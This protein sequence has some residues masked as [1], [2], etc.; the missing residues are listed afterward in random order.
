VSV[1]PPDSLIEPEDGCPQC[2]LRHAPGELFA[3]TG[4]EDHPVLDDTCELEPAWR[5]AHDAGMP[6]RSRAYH[7]TDSLEAVLAQG[8]D[9]MQTN[10]DC[11]HMPRRNPGDRRVPRG[12]WSPE[13][14]ALGITRAEG[15]G[16]RDGRPGEHPD[17]WPADIE[18]RQR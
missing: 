5:A 14:F 16:V 10:G 15:S 18:F 17:A 8:L 2:E 9:P 4:Y 6:P 1:R 7:A 11:K 12:T 13:A 3:V